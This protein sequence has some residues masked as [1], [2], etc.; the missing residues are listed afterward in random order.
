MAPWQP[1][2]VTCLS[3][4]LLAGE[5]FNEL[6]HNAHVCGSPNQDFCVDAT[7]T[8]PHIP[9]DLRIR[10]PQPEPFPPRATIRAPVTVRAPVT[11]RAP[12]TLHVP[13]G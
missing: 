4:L 11:I 13:V 10:V 3:L 1:G 12:V 6:A 7:G 8:R 9:E 2:P 5:T